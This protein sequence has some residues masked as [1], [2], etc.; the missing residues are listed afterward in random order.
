MKVKEV[1]GALTVSV[2]LQVADRKGEQE[3]IQTG[4]R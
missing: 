2:I 4:R 3:R 1:A